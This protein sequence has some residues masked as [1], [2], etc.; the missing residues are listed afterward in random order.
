MSLDEILRTYNPWWEGK[1]P[2]T[3]IARPR[4]LNVLR[5]ELRRRKVTILT[6]LRR[7]GK[8]TLLFQT[9]DELLK[10]V[11]PEDILFVSLDH[12]GLRMHALDDILREHRKIHGHPRDRRLYLFLDEVMYADSP[13]AWLKVMHDSENVKVIATSSSATIRDEKAHLTGRHSTIEILPLDLSEFLL[14]RGVTIPPS[15]PY[16]LEHEFEE[17][18]RIGGMPEYVLTGNPQVLIDLVNDIITK[19]IAAIHNIRDRQ[20]LEE[21]FFLLCERVGRRVTY[22]KLA[23][24]LK[25]TEVTL[26]SY[27]SHMVGTGLIYIVYKATRN[28]NERITSPKKVYVADVGIR[29]VI[30]GDRGKGAQFE[31]VVYMMLKDKVKGYIERKG[32]EL[33]F[34]LDDGAVECKYGTLLTPEQERLAK[35]YKAQVADGL[36]FVRGTLE[37]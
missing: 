10:E 22:A 36:G 19:D 37:L 20:K 28:S 14:F 16:L 8:T 7:V 21:L 6:G 12:P 24:M 18:L 23:R 27:V 1:A 2:A 35:R 5:E 31:N 13:M 30:V 15:E 3:G 4:Y 9:I 25:V 32:V 29:N 26:S 11:A 34:L 33:D 17:Y